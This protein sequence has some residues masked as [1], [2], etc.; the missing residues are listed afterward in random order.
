MRHLK[1][2]LHRALRGEVTCGKT[3]LAIAVLFHV[4]VYA[5]IT[6]YNSYEINSTWYLVP[7][8][9]DVMISMRYANNLAMGHGLVWNVGEFVEGYSNFLWTVIL[10]LPHIVSI[11][12]QTTFLFPVLLNLVIYFLTLRT[13][14]RLADTIQVRGVGKHLSAATLSCFLMY[15]YWGSM[16]FETSLEVLLVLV[17]LYASAT[18]VATDQILWLLASSFSLAMGWL[19]RDSFLIQVTSV[20]VASIA[21]EYA[22]R[23]FSWRDLAIH[24]SFPVAAKL[25]HTAFRFRYYGDWLPNTYYL[26]ASNWGVIDR[27][28]AGFE[29]AANFILLVSPLLMFATGPALKTL[30][31]N[32]EWFRPRQ[33]TVLAC[34]ASIILQFSYVMLVGGDAFNNYRYFVVLVP[35]FALLVGVAS[36][37]RFSTK[38][39]L[40]AS[41]PYIALV[42]LGLA[43][44]STSG[45]DFSINVSPPSLSPVNSKLP[46]HG[47]ETANQL[48]DFL[49]LYEEGSVTAPERNIR[50]AL[51]IRDEFDAKT[52]GVFYAG[53]L[54][55]LLGPEYVFTDF[56]G[57][58]D[59]AIAHSKAHPDGQP[60]HNKW[61]IQESLIAR[62]PELVLSLFR[63]NDREPIESQFQEFAEYPFLRGAQFRSSVFMENYKLA[64]RVPQ[65]FDIYDSA[66]TSG[67]RP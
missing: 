16:G 41:G 27:L 55:Y 12:K 13:I 43:M 64:L 25:L 36:H 28:G 59:P 9:E 62:K 58:M 10:T 61:D 15:A 45:I 1:T 47:R 34:C 8:R 44:I 38:R 31:T 2:I 30:K 63:I 14:A 20:L 24:L 57:K 17:A 18:Y 22:R 26:K 49:G 67:G 50:T 7:L 48:R 37:E 32:E 54:P 60:G 19:V 35:S 6:Y 21:V 53:T 23:S 11:P 29:Y 4:A 39:H 46:I 52:V 51:A 56:L 66:G 42:V 5:L 3:L 33:L 40:R 65:G